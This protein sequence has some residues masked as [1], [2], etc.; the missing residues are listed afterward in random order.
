MTG[1]VRPKKS[2]LQSPRR[3]ILELRKLVERHNR[4]YHV[5]N[6]PE[7]SDAKFDRLLKEL[8]RLEKENPRY[9]SPASPT[10][11]VGGAPDRSFR[12]VEHAVPMLSIDNTYSKE[13]VESFDGR[14]RKLLGG[15]PFEYVMELK[16]DGVSM[17]L[18]Y[19]KGVFVRAVTRGDGRR[20]DDVTGNVRTIRDVP[21]ALKAGRR[22]AP[23]VIEVRGEVFLT[24]G[25]F[26]KMNKEKEGIDEEAFAN[27]RN[28]AA[29]SLKLLDPALA[30]K[31]GLRFFA[32]GFG[33][34]EGGAFRTHEELLAFYRASG[35]PV[36]PN[37]RA[38]RDL[39]EM[40]RACDEWAERRAKLDYDIDGL[41]FKVNRLDQQAALGSTNKSPRWVIAYKFPAQRTETTLLEIGVQ[42]G[43]T[44]VLTPV[45]HL[46]PVFLAGTTV[47]R[48]TLHNEDEIARLGLKIGDR[49]RIE[50][51]GEI[52]PQVIEALVSK[53]TGREKPF[54]MPSKCPVCGSAVVREEGEVAR[55]CVNVA[56]PAQTKA[57]LLHFASRKAMDIEGLGDALVDQLV[58]RE[59]VSDVAGL[60]A[61][62]SPAL[63]GLERMGEKSASNLVGQ[64]ERSKSRGLS[65]LLFGLGIRHVGVGAARLLARHFGTMER[66]SRATRD[67]MLE[68]PSVGEVIAESVADF[69]ATVQNRR[70]LERLADS[71]VST[72]EPE[73]TSGSSELAGRTY[74]L[75]GT[76]G[77]FTRDE[78]AALIL[79]RGGR[80]ASSVSKKTTAV[81]AGEAPGSKLDEANRLGVP[82][83]DEKDFT[84]LVGVQRKVSE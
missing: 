82:V 73:D 64:I 76:L 50:K 18:L 58:D 31:R 38:C 11:R 46:E 24:R 33:R 9:A 67:Q 54:T 61:L 14:V 57:R 26:I 2:V 27:P 21:G 83:L 3:R 77:A 37:N 62:K 60:Y 20:G 51:S 40:F 56:C 29:G 48:A 1:K 63:A 43:R 55:R 34:L 32:H 59:L 36:N 84:K 7:I 39:G 79:A 23:G 45:A 52:I 71:G 17:S 66:L 15:E 6:R 41:V 44:G 47:S 78:A 28:A 16:I 4:L 30:A 75:T 25:D 65:C 70:V 68:V 69:F 53:R 13:E 10:R 42:V 22:Q 74:V 35:L 19:E 8:E 49:V 5:E 81:I 80:V 72:E 12:T